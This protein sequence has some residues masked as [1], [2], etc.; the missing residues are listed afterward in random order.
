MKGIVPDSSTSSMSYKLLQLL[1]EDQ[2]DLDAS[3]FVRMRAQTQS[4]Q[5]S[6]SEE[7]SKVPV[8]EEKKGARCFMHY[9][10]LTPRESAL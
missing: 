7:I 3:R 4:A 6:L 8:K 1:Q 2:E 9:A 5:A 10:A